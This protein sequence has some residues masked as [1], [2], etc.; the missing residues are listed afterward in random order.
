[1]TTQ[2]KFFDSNPCRFVQHVLW[3][4]KMIGSFSLLCRPKL[5]FC[6]GLWCEAGLDMPVHRPGFWTPMTEN[7]SCTFQVFRCN[8]AGKTSVFLGVGWGWGRTKKGCAM[9]NFSF[10]NP[11]SVLGSEFLNHARMMIGK[12]RFLPC[13]WFHT[14]D[15]MT[16]TI[17]DSSEIPN[18]H[19]GWRKKP[20]RWWDKLPSSTG[21]FLA[22]ISGWTI[23]LRMGA[24]MRNTTNWRYPMT[25][26]MRSEYLGMSWLCQFGIL[27]RRSWRNCLQQLC[28]G[29]KI[30]GFR[31]DRWRWRNE[32]ARLNGGFWG[33]ISQINWTR[34]AFFDGKTSLIFL[35]YRKAAGSFCLCAGSG[36]PIRK[37][38]VSN[39]NLH[40]QMFF[41]SK[42]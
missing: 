21:Y 27:C 20:C 22:G 1:M 37:K 30:P 8:F 38:K 2:A 7:P 5:P 36:R 39:E 4:L 13:F 32:V 29:P 25:S 34:W 14:L 6:E 18:N 41:L 31:V 16:Y 26:A 3:S 33:V 35:S 15:F 17:V 12:E 11:L 42:N 19:L 40:H 28:P 10:P 9:E 23:Q 24:S